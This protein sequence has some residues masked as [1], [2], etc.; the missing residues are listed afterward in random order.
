M[1]QHDARQSASDHAEI[2]PV[3]SGIELTSPHITHDCEINEQD[4]R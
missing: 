3:I 2:I 4:N 1:K